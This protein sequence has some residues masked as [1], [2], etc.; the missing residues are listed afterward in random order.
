VKV[1]AVEAEVVQVRSV[2]VVLAVWAAEE[3][4]EFI[5]GRFLIKSL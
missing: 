2:L 5:A 3:R 4:L 1:A